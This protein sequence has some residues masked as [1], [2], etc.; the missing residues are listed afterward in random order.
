MR[1][2][3][4]KVSY[5]PRDAP[6]CRRVG[7]LI[8]PTTD[9][10]PVGPVWYKFIASGAYADP[11]FEGFISPPRSTIKQPFWKPDLDH[12]DSDPVGPV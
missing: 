8:L 3:F 1:T 4:L 10:D 9:S 5:H 7:S 12:P 6:S 11:I 2:L